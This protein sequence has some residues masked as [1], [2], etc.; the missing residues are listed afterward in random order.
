MSTRAW[1][2]ELD[3]R[4]AAHL[5]RRAGFGAD[6]DTLARSVEQGLDATLAGIFAR[7]EHD[8]A[9]TQGICPLLAL[10]EL[11]PV[12]AWWMA[13]ILENGAPLV[14]RVALMWHA[15]FATSNDKVGDVRMMHGQIDLFRRKGLGDFRVL[16]RALAEDPA[17][18]VWLDGNQNRRGQPNENF[19]REVMELFALGIGNYSEH[20]V[21]EA[22]RCLTGWGVDGRSF[23][24]RE[25]YHDGG[26][27]E[28]LGRSGAFGGAE[29]IDVILAQPACSRHVARKLLQEFV[30]PKP[31]E[32]DVEEWASVLIEESWSIER[33]LDRLFR[34]E[35]FFSPEAR[36]ARISAPVELLAITLLTLGAR[37]SPAE[38]A[39]SAGAMGQS[40]FRPPSVKGWDP[41]RAWIHAGSWLTRHNLMTRIAYSEGK[42]A[43]GV[44]LARA[45]GH[46]S[47][48]AA[49]ARAARELLLPDV[50]DARLDAELR[51]AAERAPTTEHA[52]QRVAALVLTAPEYHLV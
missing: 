9:L 50:E 7:R 25:Q 36:R 40:L 29:L 13:L 3:A 46:P 18:L 17:M 15:H 43:I 45:L 6:R 47:D 37:M 10:E 39:S 52:L 8:P 35:F 42:G 12:Q 30:L 28:V 14:E 27:K 1:R 48:A 21:Q 19:A 23:V 24:F 51:E 4:A 20:D 41:G 26:T 5:W 33:T 44:D 32:R 11:A 16:L 34:S 49:I 38:A 22:A 2:G 31:S